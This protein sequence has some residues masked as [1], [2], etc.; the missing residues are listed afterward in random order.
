PV[1]REGKSSLEQII[2][3]EK[4]RGCLHL[5]LFV[6]DA[7]LMLSMPGPMRALRPAGKDRALGR[8]G[9]GQSQH[10]AHAR[11]SNCGQRLLVHLSPLPV[12]TRRTSGERMQPSGDH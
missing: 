4:E 12:G 9:S 2:R 5:L 11:Q 6:R 1:L 7:K 10:D 8:L 3:R